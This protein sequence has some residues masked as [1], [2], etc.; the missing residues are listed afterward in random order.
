[1]QTDPNEL[2]L[3]TDVPNMSR[4]FR[5]MSAL[6]ETDWYPASYPWHVVLELNRAEKKITIKK[7]EP[8]CRLIPVRRDTYFAGEMSQTGFDDFFTRGQRWLATHGRAQ[9]EGTMDITKT[10]VRQQ[11]RPK[12]V[13]L[14]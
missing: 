14:K 6:I 8:I 3:M 1:M 5:A 7:G 9:S 12:F 2:L 10:Y 11:I 4:P 13:L